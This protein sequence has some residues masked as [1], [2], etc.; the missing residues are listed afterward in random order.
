MQK[1]EHLL[2]AYTCFQV[3]TVLTQRT[4]NSVRELSKRHLRTRRNSPTRHSHSAPLEANK[5]L[6]NKLDEDYNKG[7]KYGS[8]DQL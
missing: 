7:H 2:S 6:A 1:N 3:K 8:D 4:C 5:Y